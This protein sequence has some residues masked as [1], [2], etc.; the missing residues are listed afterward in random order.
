[1]DSS[2]YTRRVLSFVTACDIVRHKML[3]SQ[4]RRIEQQGRISRAMLV[5]ANP[6]LDIQGART[7]FPLYGLYQGIMGRSLLYRASHIP[8]AFPTSHAEKLV[9]CISG[10]SGA[11]K[12][13]LRKIIEKN[14]PGQTNKLRTA[15][16]RPKRDTDG[17]DDYYFFESHE[18]FEAAIARGE[19]LEVSHQGSPK[20]GTFRYYGTPK[21]SLDEALQRPERIIITH[22]EMSEGW[23]NVRNYVYRTFRNA[24]VIRMFILPVMRAKEYFET[25]LK[26]KRPVDH[27]DRAIRAGWEFMQAPRVSDILVENTVAEGESILARAAEQSMSVFQEH[28]IAT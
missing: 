25:W 11:G 26:E 2:V 17:P 5:D 22:V 18:A 6:A 19:F 3:T 7:V 1:M 12:D 10:P 4:E 28:L 24:S 23:P 14:Y 27:E 8:S 20:D 13:T 15:T 16:S 9:V 21:R